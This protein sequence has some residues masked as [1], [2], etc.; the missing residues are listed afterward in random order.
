VI[1]GSWQQVLIVT[2]LVLLL[3]G[4]LA[5]LIERVRKWRRAA[6]AERLCRGYQR[7]RAAVDNRCSLATF[8]RV[9]PN[10]LYH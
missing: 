5:L 9:V 3:L 7:Y 1:P 4:M 10:R 6:R 2:L 8:R